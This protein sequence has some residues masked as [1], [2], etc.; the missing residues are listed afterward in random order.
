MWVAFMGVRPSTYGLDHGD[1]V[2]EHAGSNAESLVDLR[3]TN[4]TERRERFGRQDALDQE[5]GNRRQA[6]GQRQDG[7][8]A[9]RTRST[10]GSWPG[11]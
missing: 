5:H 1:E 2:V 8:R 10:A 7:P 9:L 6:G 4:E 11:S 3:D